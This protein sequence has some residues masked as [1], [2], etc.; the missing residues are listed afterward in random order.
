MM[1]RQE[2]VP[3]EQPPLKFGVIVSRAINRKLK[4]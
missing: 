3:D 2:F 4:G 1:P